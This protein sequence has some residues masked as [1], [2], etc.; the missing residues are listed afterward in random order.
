M[1]FFGRPP[2]LP[3]FLEAMIFAAVLDRPPILPS[4]T[5]LG[6]FILVTFTIKNLFECVFDFHKFLCVFHYFV[7]ILIRLWDFVEQDIC[8]AV[9]YAYHRL[10]KVLHC[11]TFTRLST[12][13]ST[14]C[15]VW[16]RVE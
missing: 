16:R 1:V 12:R 3:F 4:A 7:Y 5:A 11:V 15:A 2:F 8:A 14:S 10:V 13:E 9:F 6:F